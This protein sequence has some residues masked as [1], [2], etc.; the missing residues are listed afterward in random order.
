MLKHLQ[1]GPTNMLCI[2]ILILFC[3]FHIFIDPLVQKHEL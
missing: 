2:M 3:V 1:N